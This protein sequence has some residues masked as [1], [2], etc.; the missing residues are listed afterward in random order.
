VKLGFLAPLMLSACAI[1]GGAST[2]PPA[3]DVVTSTASSP[4]ALP[5]AIA[6]P[7]APAPDGALVERLREDVRRV[8]VRRDP[9]SQG[10]RDVRAFI[11]Q[12]LTDL[13]YAPTLDAFP[14]GGVN[15]VAERPGGAKASETVIL[16][17]HYDHV[18]DCAGADDNASGV[19]VVLEAARVLR[20]AAPSRKI[21]LAFWDY[22][23]DGLVGSTAWAR[24]ARARGDRIEMV[25]SLDGVGYVDPRPG[26]QSLPSGAENLLPDV[27]RQL[28][29]GGYRGDFIALIADADSDRHV[30]AFDAFAT[31]RG[32]PHVAVGLNALTRV[33]L[34]DAARSDHASFWL[35]GYPGILVTDTANFRNPRY[36]CASGSDSPD[37]LDY[38]FLARVA[39]AVIDTTK[40]AAE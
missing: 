1:Q 8:A 36:H 3:L 13:G 17:A 9:G 14:Q 29:T 10:W 16:S 6:P 28:K 27:A 2:D 12:R 21:V 15:V 20:D 33:L 26:S 37:S 24:K 7:P 19:A 18:W 23:E 34:L 30:E 32:L 5:S 31:A 39:G 22:E 40:A 38:E 4:T 11:S 35:M 25:I